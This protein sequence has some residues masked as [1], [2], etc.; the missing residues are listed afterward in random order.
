MRSPSPIEH[1][2]NEF[3]GTLYVAAD[4]IKARRAEEERQR[5][6]REEEQ[7]RRLEQERRREAEAKRE[8]DF[9]DS[10]ARW[11]LA[12]DMRAYVDEV[13][14]LIDGANLDVVPGGRAGKE[15][16]WALAYADR[17]DPISEWRA[18]I[19]KVPLLAPVTR[20]TSLFSM[21]SIYVRPSARTWRFLA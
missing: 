9:T 3:V 8:K 18:E 15:I 17:L 19:A 16:A 21:A 5:V 7:R 10:I 20:A 11:R 14:A 12:R 4:A 6:A 2:L 13:R 1:C